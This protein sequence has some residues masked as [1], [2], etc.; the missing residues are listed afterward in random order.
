MGSHQTLVEWRRVFCWPFTFSPRTVGCCEVG[1]DLTPPAAVWP[2]GA[3]LLPGCGLLPFPHI[4]LQASALRGGLGLSGSVACAHHE[5]EGIAH[6][7][8]AVAQPLGP[9]LWASLASPPVA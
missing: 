9:Q 1:S 2:V 7:P 5:G 4:P 6:G 8:Q 3:V